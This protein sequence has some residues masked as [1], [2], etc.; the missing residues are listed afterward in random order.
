MVQK[1]ESALVLAGFF[2]RSAALRPEQAKTGPA[3]SSCAR[4]CGA[5]R[6]RADVSSRDFETDDQP[7]RQNRPLWGL[8][9]RRQNGSRCTISRRFRERFLLTTQV[10]FAY[11]SYWQDRERH[12]RGASEMSASCRSA[13]HRWVH[14]AQVLEIALVRPRAASAGKPG[15][16]CNS[17]DC[18]LPV[19]S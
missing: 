19:G 14:S 2:A 4:A 18:D 9:G 3:G 16:A 13:G 10:R 11:N 6:K 5:R 8:D 12:R 7:S 15:K 17:V 1:G